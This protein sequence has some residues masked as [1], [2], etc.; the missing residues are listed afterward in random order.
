MLPNPHPKANPLRNPR[1]RRIS[2]WTILRMTTYRQRILPYL[3]QRKRIFPRTRTRQTQD[4]KD[5]FKTVEQTPPPN[6]PGPIRHSPDTFSLR[7]KSLADHTTSTPFQPPVASTPMVPAHTG[8]I[9]KT[10]RHDTQIGP[11]ASTSAGNTP[12]LPRKK[13]TWLSVSR[14]YPQA[15]YPGSTQENGHGS[16]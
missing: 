14:E 5:S 9:P 13:H 3:K 2:T 6:S 12:K 4:S 11:G 8:A 1:T 10:C 16:S 7:R 15:S